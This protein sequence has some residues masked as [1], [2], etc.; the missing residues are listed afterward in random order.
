[1][2]RNLLGAACLC[3][4]SF[5]DTRDT[6]I[7][8]GPNP[9]KCWFE[10]KKPVIPQM[11]E[12]QSQINIMKKTNKTT[13]GHLIEAVCKSVSCSLRLSTIDALGQ[14]LRLATNPELQ[15][16]ELGLFIDG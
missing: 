12:N 7:S 1:M 9:G 10:L 4:D 13:F 3:R 15:G 5:K 6:L 2:L 14:L 16:L 8:N 11:A